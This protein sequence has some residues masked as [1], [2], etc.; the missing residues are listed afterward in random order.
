[1]RA[2]AALLWERAAQV[3]QDR[4]TIVD[5]RDEAYTRYTEASE[6]NPYDPSLNALRRHYEE[7]KRLIEKLAEDEGRIERALLSLEA[8]EVVNLAEFL[9]ESREENSALSKKKRSAQKDEQ[10]L[11]EQNAHLAAAAEVLDPRLTLQR[12]YEFYGLGNPLPSP[13]QRRLTTGR[14]ATGVKG[15]FSPE[16]AEHAFFDATI[17]TH[18][19]KSRRS[20]HKKAGIYVRRDGKRI[21]KR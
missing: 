10:Y 21:R 6:K 2:T 8:G 13:Q 5:E 18:G 14:H 3:S 19:G 12:L 20:H 15:S 16:E 9:G 1:M 17:D 7:L 11:R 4:A